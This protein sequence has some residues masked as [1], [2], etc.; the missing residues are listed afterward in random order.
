MAF[1]ESEKM[2]PLSDASIFHSEDRKI[3]SAFLFFLITLNIAQATIITV[4]NRT[5]DE[6]QTVLLDISIDPERSKIAGLQMNIMFDSAIVKVNNV[7][8]GIFLK[9][10]G[11][12]T[13][14]N[15]G[16]VDNSAG[17]IKNS[18]KLCEYQND[19]DQG[20]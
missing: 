20:G 4:E 11:L 13:F 17:I 18:R 16:M 5:I 8:E 10:S 12:R 6:G 2:R 9:N 19:W 7:I 14:Y 15:E 1:K 3:F